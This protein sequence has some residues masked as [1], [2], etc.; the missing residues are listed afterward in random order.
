MAIDKPTPDQIEVS[1]FGPGYGESVVVHLG[2]GNWVIIDSCYNSRTKESS[3]IAY[4]KEIGV[5]VSADV[6]LIVATHWHDDHIRGLGGCLE[7]CENA[8]FCCSSAFGEAQFIQMIKSYAEDRTIASGSGTKESA[9]IIDMLHR[10]RINTPIAAINDR[11][12]FTLSEKESGHGMHC[13]VTS[14]SPSDKQF[15]E[16]LLSIPSMLPVAG[17]TKK[18]ASSPSPNHLCVVTQIEIGE[19]SILLG[20]DHEETDDPETGWSVILN[21]RNKP[22][23]RSIIFKVPHHGSETGDVEGVWREMLVDNPIA[24]LTPFRRSGLPREDMVRRILQR[25]SNAY[26][27]AKVDGAKSPIIRRSN[28]VERI[29]KS[30]LKS[31]RPLLQMG[32]IRLRNGGAEDADSWRVDLF[33]GACELALVRGTA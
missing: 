28:T 25:T 7:E 20:A 16:F 30:K 32:H 14:L 17:E 33:S 3:P 23:T 5:D 22:Q 6:R 21:S 11:R 31:I 15:H 29:M 19:Q 24:L 9:K 12:I 2:N 27:T 10:R 18:R 1:L 8:S 4:L 26:S 13:K